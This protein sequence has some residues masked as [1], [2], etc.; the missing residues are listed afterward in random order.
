[1]KI[2][3]LVQAIGFKSWAVDAKPEEVA[4]ALAAFKKE[5][6]EDAEEHPAKCRCEDCKPG[7]K[8]KKGAK[9]KAK[10]EMEESEAA[11]KAAKDAAA[12]KD[13]EEKEAKDAAAKDAEEKEKESAKDEAEVLPAE[14]RPASEFSVGDALSALD[15][16]R[17]VMARSKDAGAIKTYNALT[18]KMRKVRDGV[19]DGALEDP[20]VSLVNIG[21]AVAD[22]EP[23]PAML[24]FF[25]G[26]THAEGLKAYNAYLASKGAK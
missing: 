14:T 24:S 9:D 26:K 19:K 1:M 13:A 4:D 7:A 12:A 23:E 8:D 17:P 15:A 11:D 22:A 10:D 21:S 20:F 25:N 18:E 5:G 16:I 3:D 6:A 2:R